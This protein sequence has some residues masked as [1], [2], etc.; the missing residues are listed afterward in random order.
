MWTLPTVDPHS[1]PP[2]WIPTVGGRRSG[3]EGQERGE[4]FL[5]SPPPVFAADVQ[6]TKAVQTLK[7]DMLDIN[8]EDV[9]VMKP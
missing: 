6:T 5:V 9:C 4:H 8:R 2:Q 1:G 3:H 7:S